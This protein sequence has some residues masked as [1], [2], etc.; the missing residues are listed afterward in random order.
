M[1]ED[2]VGLIGREDK[3]LLLFDDFGYWDEGCYMGQVNDA[4][5]KEMKKAN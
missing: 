3:K 2:A 1:D 5:I 4:T